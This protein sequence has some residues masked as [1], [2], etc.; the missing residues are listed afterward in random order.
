MPRV[1]I[2]YDVMG[3]AQTGKTKI[4]LCVDGEFHQVDD[5]IC[6]VPTRS[7]V[8]CED[9]PRLMMYAEAAEVKISGSKAVVL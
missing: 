3:S 2:Y 7:I 9:G 1:L 8:D 4:A 6:H 5:V